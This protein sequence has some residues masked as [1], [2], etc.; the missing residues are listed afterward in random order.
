MRDRPWFLWDV[1]ITDAEFRKR[2]QHPDPSIRA[3]W[4]GRLLRVARFEEVWSYVRLDDV[5]ENWER[6][7]RHLGRQRAFWDWLIE[8]WRKDGL[9]PA[10]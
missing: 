1:D 5:L 2:L 4:Q 8:G 7:R 6:I 10:A 9:L 3:Q